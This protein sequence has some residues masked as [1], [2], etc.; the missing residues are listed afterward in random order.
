MSLYD[1]INAVTDR[2][3]RKDAALGH[4]HYCPVLV[5]HLSLT[6]GTFQPV[7]EDTLLNDPPPRV[8]NVSPKLTGLDVGGGTASAI[9]VYVSANDKELRI[10]RS[11]PF[12]TFVRD[13]SKRAHL[14]LGVEFDAT[15]EVVYDD[16]LRNLSHPA[17]EYTII[18]IDDRDC[19]E[20]RLIIRK[21][22]DQNSR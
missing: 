2:A 10:S 21:A 7:I 17:T 15:G 4:P 5:R 3:H 22:R 11:V 1:R 8:T 16:A 19:C 9:S 13:D 12:D 6:P 18:H 20:W 14:W